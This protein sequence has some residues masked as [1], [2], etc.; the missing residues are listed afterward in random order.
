MSFI[1]G[2]GVGVSDV[3]MLNNVGNRTPPRGTTVWNCKCVCF[4]SF[5]V[6]CDEFDNGV[7]AVCLV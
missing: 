4:S 7:W 6:V 1:G 3:Y 5:D 2:C